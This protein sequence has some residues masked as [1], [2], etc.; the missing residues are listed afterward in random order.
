MNMGDAGEIKGAV[1]RRDALKLSA[2]VAGAAA[3]AT[4]V[5]VGAFSSPAMA[6]HGGICTPGNDS[7]AETAVLGGGGRWNVNCAN[8]GPLGRY[9]GQNGH[10]ELAD[11]TE[12]DVV[13][14]YP[15]VDN[16][17]VRCSFYTIDVPGYVCSATF[18]LDNCAC[19]V[20]QSVP[21]DPIN[22]PGD[23]A[24]PPNAQP[25]PYCNCVG[26]CSGGAN[27]ASVKLILTSVNCCPV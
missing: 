24:C 3:F 10:F 15:G 27:V 4:P 19:P 7:D 17:D 12:G 20:A 14:G 11:G 8:A 25:L 23:P 26:G 9:N 18:S 21:C 16:F 1:S 2:K 6:N 22:C 5:V 13:I